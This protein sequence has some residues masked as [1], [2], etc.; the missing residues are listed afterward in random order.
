MNMY[1]TPQPRQ[2]DKMATV[3]AQ[4]LAERYTRTTN[5]VL[6]KE[7]TNLECQYS[8]SLLGHGMLPATADPI[9][10]LHDSGAKC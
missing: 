4:L 8:S 1:S 9:P 10:R 7:Q 6:A 3:N 2:F 5:L